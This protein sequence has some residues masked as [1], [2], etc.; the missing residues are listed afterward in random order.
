MSQL[1]ESE[2]ESEQRACAEIIYGVIRGSRFWSFEDG[3]KTSRE[4][5]ILMRIAFEHMSLETI[6]DWEAMLN[7]ATN[8][9]DTNR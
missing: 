5:S 8:K 7:G 4:L 9:I 6:A 1:V 3:Q 2:Q